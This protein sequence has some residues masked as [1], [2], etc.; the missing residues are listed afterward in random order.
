MLAEILKSTAR[1]RDHKIP[2]GVYDFHTTFLV[3]CFFYFHDT[4]TNDR[5]IV[6]KSLAELPSISA[7]ASGIH[8]LVPVCQSTC[9]SVR[10]SFCLSGYLPIHPSVSISP[11]VHI[12]LS[13]RRMYGTGW[14]IAPNFVYRVFRTYL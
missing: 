9:T 13:F 7:S 1:K 5:Y 6:I 2:A 14:T 4:N 12:V 10:L 11:S 3:S 8:Q